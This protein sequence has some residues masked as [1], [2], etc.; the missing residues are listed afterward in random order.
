MNQANRN[1]LRERTDGWLSEGRVLGS[2]VE[3]G[4]GGEAQMGSN[5]SVRDVKHRTGTTGKRDC[6][7]CQVGACP[8]RGSLQ[9]FCTCQPPCSHLELMH[10]DLDYE[11][12]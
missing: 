3:R 1:R 5:K 11:C 9:K 7:W 8:V 2:E 12:N 4:R 6:G 10:T